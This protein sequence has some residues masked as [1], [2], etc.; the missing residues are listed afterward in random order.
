MLRGAPDYQRALTVGTLGGPLIVRGPLTSRG[1][2]I[3][4]GPLTDGRAPDIKKIT[5]DDFGCHWGP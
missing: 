3:F 4:I 5:D 1:S 2:L